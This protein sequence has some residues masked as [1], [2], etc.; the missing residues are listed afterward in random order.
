MIMKSPL[1]AFQTLPTQAEYNGNFS[2]QN[3]TIYDPT[4]TVCNASACVRTAYTNNTIP[5]SKQSKVAQYM[6]HFLPQHVTLPTTTGNNFI[7]GYPYGLNNWM[8][9]ERV[10]WVI[11]SKN[12]LSLTFAKGRQVTA[13]GPASQTT[14][15]RNVTPWAPYNFV[16]IRLQLERS[17][18]V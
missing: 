15:G 18:V 2:D 1:P 16:T 13:G 7:G 17:A 6:Q 8:T 10:D 11:N 14:P 5:L 4:S 9:T 12:T 3:L